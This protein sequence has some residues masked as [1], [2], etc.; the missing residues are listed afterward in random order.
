MIADAKTGLQGVH[1]ANLGCAIA[2]SIAELANVSAYVVDPISVDEFEPLAR[3]SGHPLI[4]RRA[5]SH[6][7]NIHAVGRIAAEKV[8]CR[9]SKKQILLLP[10][11]VE[12]FPSVHLK[13]AK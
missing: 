7:L 2:K 3:Y 1:A 9:L 8:S 12:A 13:E 6:T 10:T 11:S 4:E 5:L